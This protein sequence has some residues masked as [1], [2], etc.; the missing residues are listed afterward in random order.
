MKK[1]QGNAILRKTRKSLKSKRR[2]RTQRRKKMQGGTLSGKNLEE[3]Y[4]KQGDLITKLQD[5]DGRIDTIETKQ[6]FIGDNKMNSL[7]TAKENV[8]KQIH[9][10]GEE[11]KNEEK[12]WDSN[13]DNRLAKIATNGVKNAIKRDEQYHKTL[14]GGGG[15]LLLLG[16]VGGVIAIVATK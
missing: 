9:N 13:A 3:L 14:L 5:I 4:Q 12:K 16:I 10:I 8:E 2:G 11:I 6:H 7:K 1:K 15:T